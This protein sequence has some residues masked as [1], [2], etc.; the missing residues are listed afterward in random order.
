MNF[1]QQKSR[2]SLDLS[3]IMDVPLRIK[4]NQ[5]FAGTNILMD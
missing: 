3:L 5:H 4:A 1:V 2:E